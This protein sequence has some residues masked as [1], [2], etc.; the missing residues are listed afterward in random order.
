M[1]SSDLAFV[2]G[3][4]VAAN[5]GGAD[6][7]LAAR[8]QPSPYFEQMSNADITISPAGHKGV[9]LTGR[10]MGAVGLRLALDPELRKKANDE[11]DSWLKKYNE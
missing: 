10:V 2:V 4:F 5:A 11:F 6:A 9:V 8:L 3:V 1:N 7:A